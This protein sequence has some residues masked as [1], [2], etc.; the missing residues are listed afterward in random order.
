MTKIAVVTGAAGGMGKAICARLLDD[1]FHV[2]GVD[3]AWSDQ[4]ASSANDAFT[5]ETADLADEAAVTA[6]FERIAAQH[7][8]V[9][10][11]VN[12]AGTCFMS[13]FPKIPAAAGIFGKSDMKQVPA[14][15]TSRSTP[16][17]CA[18]MRSNRAVTAASS[19]RSAVSMV[20]ASFALLAP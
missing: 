7:G 12:N 9:D 1:G 5:I 3:M 2:V 14:L 17:C 19:A 8:G 10:L 4:G 13:D 11:L 6:L 15:F 18:A 16:P 20:K